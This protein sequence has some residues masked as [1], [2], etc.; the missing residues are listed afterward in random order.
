MHRL[1]TS[2]QPAVDHPCPDS[3]FGDRLF[4]TYPEASA[5]SGLGPGEFFRRVQDGE[6][7]FVW[8]DRRK[9][10]DRRDIVEIRA[11]AVQRPAPR[12]AVRRRPRHVIARD[13]LALPCI[14][15]EDAS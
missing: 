13:L 12:L 4:I 5:F 8:L 2:G 6:I 3:L 14:A 11:D 1:T 7:P 10:F 9:L 15:T